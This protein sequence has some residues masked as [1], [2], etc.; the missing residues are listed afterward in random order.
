MAGSVGP[1][2]AYLA[3]GSEYRGDYQRSAEAFQA[4]HRPRVEALLDAG[5]DLLACETLP[6]FAEI[7]A[8]AAL[9]RDYP[10]ARAQFSLTL[11]D[12]EHLSDGTPL[13]EVVAVLADNPQVLA[14]GI[15]C[16]ALENTT[17]ALQHLHSLTSLPLVVY[18]N[19]GEH[20]DALTKTRHHHGEACATLAAYLPQ[21]LAAG[22]ADWRLLSHHAAGYRRAGGGPLTPVFLS[23]D[24]GAPRLIRATSTASRGT[25][26][27]NPCF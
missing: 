20:Y 23:P 6:S 27:F 10:R 4:F 3:D 13:R 1:Y 16:I 14:L 2:G 19:S 22:A 11:R 15:N 26:F 21:W 25:H 5:A 24:G 17:A 18:P 9:L 7:T 8:L 12:A